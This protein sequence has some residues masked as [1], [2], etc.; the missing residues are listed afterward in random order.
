M[1]ISTKH[2][3]SETFSPSSVCLLSLLHSDQA[4]FYAILATSSKCNRIKIMLL[5]FFFFF[6]FTYAH[7]T[8]EMPSNSH[9]SLSEA[10]TPSFVPGIVVSSHLY[11]IHPKPYHYY[12]YQFGDFHIYLTETHSS[13]C[14]TPP[15]PSHQSTP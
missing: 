4:K 8:F 1:F 3:S 11:H 15:S 7:L 14:P 13:S 5:F 2:F 9:I 10:P 6:Y 12:L